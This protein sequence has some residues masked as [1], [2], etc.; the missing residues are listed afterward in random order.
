MPKGADHLGA[1]PLYDLKHLAFSFFVV[2][3]PGGD[4][5]TDEIPVEGFSHVCLS[6]KEFLVLICGLDEAKALFVTLE[7]TSV[8]ARGGLGLVLS[9]VALHEPLGGHLCEHVA[10]LEVGLIVLNVERLRNLVRAVG[11]VGV[12]LQKGEDVL[13]ETVN[14]RLRNGSKVLCGEKEPE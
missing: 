5:H 8:L 11:V 6:E 12:L 14:L 4:G 9:A 7:N 2:R 3:G 10:E 13:S 1:P